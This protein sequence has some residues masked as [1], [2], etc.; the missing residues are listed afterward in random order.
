[1]NIEQTESPLVSVIL[2][3]RNAQKYL[4]LCLT[5][6]FEQ[7]YTNLEIIAIDDFSSDRSYSILQQF[8]M[9]YSRLN[10]SRNVKRYGPAITLN[11]ALKKVKGQYVT[12]IKAEDISHKDRFLK[13]ISFLL[14]N[15]KVVGVGS[16]CY[17]INET[18][19]RIGKSEFPTEK[20]HIY[21]KPFHA[22][23]IQFEGLMINRFL[24]PNDLLYFHTDQQPFI[25]S[26]ILVKLLKY[27]SLENLPFYLFMHR[28]FRI[29]KPSKTYNFLTTAR[30]W[31][32]SE[33]LFGY[34]PSL[35][36]FV[37]PLLRIKIA[38]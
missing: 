2:P 7:S 8:A 38:A 13:Q 4:S 33:A 17:F 32:R 22:V 15:K 16:Q 27:G 11:R 12:F 6:I 30:F 31:L 28:K 34:R 1:M 37:F 21:Q 18:G 24:I 29:D 19:K 35:R 10:L 25:Y 36:S 20:L 3:V 5:S 9:K 26:D 23:S 14:K